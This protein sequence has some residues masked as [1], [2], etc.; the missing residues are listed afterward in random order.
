MKPWMHVSNLGPVGCERITRTNQQLGTHARYVISYAGLLHFEMHTGRMY[1]PQQCNRVSGDISVVLMF[2]WLTLL[3]LMRAMTND[4][5]D[6]GNGRSGVFLLSS[7]D[8]E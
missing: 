6:N 4:T 8:F 7:L 5:K 3:L 2:C 1:H